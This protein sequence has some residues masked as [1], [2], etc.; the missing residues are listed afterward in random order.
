MT[1]L[2][3][4]MSLDL[5]SANFAIPL[6]KTAPPDKLDY[7]EK[8][9]WALGLR[10]SDPYAVF[11]SEAWFGDNIGDKFYLYGNGK[12]LSSGS[13]TTKAPRYFLNVLLNDLLPTSLQEGLVDIY[14]EVLRNSGQTSRSATQKYLVKK[15]HPAGLDRRPDIFGH[16]G[17]RVVA[18]G[19]SPDADIDA[20]T[21]VN[22]MWARV[23][24]YQNA[25][26]NDEIAVYL[27]GV[28]T[29]RRLSA[30]EAAGVGPHRVFIPPAV[31]GRISQS[32][33]VALICTVTDVAG[34]IPE[35]NDKYSPPFL[36]NSN[37]DP[38][39]FDSPLF[40]VNGI[41]STLLD[42]GTQSNLPLSVLATPP[43]SIAIASP[44]NQLVVTLTLTKADGTRTSKR[45]P[46]F[47]H[48]QRAG[49]QTV[50]PNEYFQEEG[51]V[52]LSFE[53]FT[54]TGGLLGRSGSSTVRLVGTV[55]P[56]VLPHPT[57]SGASSM[58]QATT[59]DPLVI[60]NSTR[61]TVQYPG[62]RVTD[63]ITQIWIYSNGY[64]YKT[65]LNGQASGV[66]V[67]DL[68]SARVLHNSVNSRVQLQYLMVRDGKTTRSNIQTVSIGTIAP[69][70]LPRALIN[71]LSPGAALV[72]S[73]FSGNAK[74]SVNTWPLMKAGQRAWIIITAGGR[75]LRVLD[76]YS[77]TDQEVTGGL[78]DKVVSRDWLAGVANGTV[79]EVKLW[80]AF[81]GGITLSSAVPF[82]TTTYTANMRVNPPVIS[83]VLVATTGT[84]LANGG[85]Y[86]NS[87][88]VGVVFSGT[89]DALPY[90]RRVRLGPVGSGGHIITIP[91]GVGYWQEWAGPTPLNQYITYYLFEDQI[92][93][94]VRSNP[95]TYFRSA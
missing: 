27:D 60:Q 57:L 90:A 28:A 32:G 7:P 51:F 61:I 43:R 25:R 22:G 33:T 54:P 46:P 17:L 92:D 48:T 35:G 68:T 52:R 13:I 67:F 69:T 89:C 66:V 65:T 78:V 41:E 39:L 71:L 77:V 94:T 24:K 4:D 95:F 19:F 56:S 15:T 38:S 79:I 59:V 80:V 88:G 55:Q 86:P 85:S 16:D 21:A 73:G 50:V 9:Q 83:R 34:N 87:Q 10:A 30:S 29:K 37:L 58:A 6:D 63:S 74:A 75:E 8:A 72:L 12:L 14:W 40:Y 64:E 84:P 93:P 11:A 44:P 62:M 49:N 23:D 20:N 18:E 91:A 47:A 31:F 42:L 53:L 76:A 2:P 70:Y 36:L 5:P 26:E 1:T 81:D 45:L 82:P 3:I